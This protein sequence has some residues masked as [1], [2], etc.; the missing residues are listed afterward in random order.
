MITSHEDILKRILNES[1]AKIV[2][3]VTTTSTISTSTST[4]VTTFFIKSSQSLTVFEKYV[5]VIL[6]FVAFVFLMMAL[7]LF[8]CMKQMCKPIKAVE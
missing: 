2:T 6:F 3:T 7:A 1:T 4:I 8:L 5:A